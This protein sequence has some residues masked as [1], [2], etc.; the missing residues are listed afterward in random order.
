MKYRLRKK[1]GHITEDHLEA[2]ITLM[3][4]YRSVTLEDIRE[5]QE[6]STGFN[7]CDV[8]QNITGFGDSNTCSLCKTA[9]DRC[10]D[11]IWDIATK[12]TCSFGYNRITYY[13]IVYA[14]G[15][16]DLLFAF[17]AR[18]NRMEDQLKILL[19]PKSFEQL[20]KEK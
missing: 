19:T 10:Q 14:K 15:P 5:V 12:A 18:A 11:C 7:G 1:Y 16:I 2:F 13:D 8:A 20:I 6:S 17:T 4:K 3:K 9:L